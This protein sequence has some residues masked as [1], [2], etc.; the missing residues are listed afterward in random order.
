[1]T[2]RSL[3]FVPGARSDRFEKALA[4]G[5][6]AVCIDL[7]DAVAPAEKT[8]AR[9]ETL[10]FLKRPREGLG[11]RINAMTT[12]DGLRDVVALAETGVRP[13]FL[14]VPKAAG[15]DEL[16]QLRAVLG[17]ACPPLWPL[18]ETPEAFHALPALARAVGETGGIV[19]GGADYSAALGSDMGWDAFLAARSA[20]LAAA[21]LSG[22][23]TLDVPHLDVR[24]EAGLRAGTERVK[25]L[26]FTGRACIHPDQVPVVNAVFTPTVADTARAEAVVAAYRAASGGV[27][28]L[29]GKLVEKPVLRAA[30]RVLARKGR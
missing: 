27:A 13:A 22:C 24:D 21:A 18:M 11:L 7:E 20:I 17:E 25:A 1:M 14:M 4:A 8:R 30:E 19:F 28:L 29:D 23:G 5:A 12:V 26:G 9:G 3:L 6:D 16:L 2:Y 10:D 15:A